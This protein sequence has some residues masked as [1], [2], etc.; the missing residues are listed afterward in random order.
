MVSAKAASPVIQRMPT[1][2]GEDR[3][4]HVVLD[5][6]GNGA[7]TSRQAAFADRF[8]T[9]MLTQNIRI[10]EDLIGQLFNSS[11][12]RLARTLLLLEKGRLWPTKMSW[13]RRYASLWMRSID[14]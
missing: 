2:S 5:T 1:A 7:A 4:Y 10:E 3:V 8:L 12:T 11:E 9:R 6:L 13:Y 14:E